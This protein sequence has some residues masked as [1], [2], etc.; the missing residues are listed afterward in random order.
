VLSGSSLTEHP[1]AADVSMRL[2]NAFGA[3][4]SLVPRRAN[5][6]GALRCGVHPALLPGGRRID[7]TGGRAEVERVWGELPNAV[8]GRNA[9][10][11][12][13]AAA[14]REIDVLFLIGVDPL[15][16]FPDAVAVRHALGNVEYK[17]VQSLELGSLE[18]FAD[19]VLP[20][21]GFLEKDGHY[22]DWE[23]RSQRLRAVRGPAGI[24]RPDWEIFVGLA[25]AMGMS[26]G[27]RDLEELQEEMARLTAPRDVRIRSDAYVGTG[28]PQYIEN[29]TLFTYPLLV[30]EGRL[31]EGAAELKAALEADPFVEVNPEDAEKLRLA[32]G[33]RARL[34]TEAG[35]AEVPVRVTPHVAAGAV[36]VPFNQ[37][38]LAANALLSGRFSTAVTVERAEASA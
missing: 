29:L 31:L 34:T 14:N 19:A 35:S 30:D 16:D 1:L 17:V 7:D 22:T 37:P 20:A 26:L 18:P 10:Q 25:D 21:A 8:P 15:R 6:R 3:R 28:R 5:D 9:H 2:A 11:I 23:G 12:L 27:F 13:R 33:G 32:H 36:F 24:A 38:G 4:F